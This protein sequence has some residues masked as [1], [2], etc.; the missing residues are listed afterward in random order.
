[1]QSSRFELNRLTPEAA[2]NLRAA[3][4]VIAAGVVAALHVGKLPPALPVLKEVLDVSLL[5]AGFLLSL[6]QLAGMT[7]GLLTGLA[8]QRIGL[9]RS[10]VAGLLL[11]AFASALGGMAQS[12]FWLLATRVLEGV[13][14]LWAVLP[15]PGLVRKLVPHE[16]LQGMLGAWGAY[17]P[18]GTSLAL[19]AGPWVMHLVAPEWGW[20]IWWWLLS[21]LAVML[22]L[23]L[24]WRVRSDHP[25]SKPADRA[26]QAPP[27]SQTLTLLRLT[28]CSRAVWLLALTFAMYAGQWLAVIGFLPSIYAQAGLP[29]AMTAWLTAGAAAVN[30]LGN[31][32]AGHMLGRGHP[33]FALLA[34]GFVAMAFGALLAFGATGFPVWQYAGVLVFSLLG[35]LIPATLFSLSIRMAPSTDTVSTTVGW[36][37][38]WS[39]LGQF[40]GPPLVAWVAALVGGWQLTG[41]IAT[42]CCVIGVYLAWQIHDLLKRA[43]VALLKK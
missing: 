22:A 13:G 2:Q 39:A 5:Q 19:L 23:L 12:P 41:W 32:L 24:C 27:N 29:S 38:Q 4:Y 37:Q 34:T 30:I 40:A 6:V 43:P 20:R 8:A 3:R 31:L 15:A 35:G 14:F 28:L 18:L 17:M 1:M 42:V 7:L 11:L 25:I 33:P 9:K 21:G 26:Q 16:R 36:M 10:M